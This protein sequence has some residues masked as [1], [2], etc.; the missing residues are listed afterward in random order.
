MNRFLLLR[1][2]AFRLLLAVF[3]LL[4]HVTRL[5]TGRL[6]VILF[7]VLSGYWI[8]DLWDRQKGDAPLGL[9][10]LNRF[11]RIWPLY[12]IC[13]FISAYL[14]S[15]PIPAIS[16][17]LFGVATVPK[18]VPIGVEWSLDVEAQ[19]Y[20]LLPF[21]ALRKP[22]AWLIVPFTA[23]GWALMLQ[24]GIVTVLAYLP[25]FAAG[26]WLY[27]RRKQP[28]PFNLWHAITAI[29]A[30]VSICL[31]VPMLR[32]QFDYRYPNALHDDVFAF[33]WAVSFLPYIALSLRE[34]SSK[35]DRHLGN[36]SYPLYLIH[37][38]AMQYLQMGKAVE[39]AVAFLAALGLYLVFDVPIEK[40]RYRLLG[41]AALARLFARKAAQ[42]V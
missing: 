21:F 16:Y 27:R 11:F 24:T 26:I 23:I 10:F 32:A 18:A 19:F 6:G 38:P 3:V 35:F 31:A 17:G 8:S 12:I 7:F 22:P 13:V 41:S 36:L 30:F 39:I 9:F 33:A 28:L 29:V 2:G 40:L 5:E 15:R 37:M 4:C 20:L 1:P 34:T 14:L 42:T 25:A